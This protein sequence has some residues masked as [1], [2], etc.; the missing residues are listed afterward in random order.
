QMAFD[1][2]RNV[3]VL[4]GGYGAGGAVL[5][6]T[7]EWNGSS[8]TQRQ[9]NAPPARFNHGLAYDSARHVC[10]LVGGVNSGSNPVPFQDTWEWNG[11]AWTQRVV[12]GPTS[13]GAA[14]LAYDASRGATV[15]H[16]QLGASPGHDETWEW[17][18]T[19]WTER[20][21]GGNG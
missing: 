20:A 2:A 6:D 3:T 1:S 5:G 9:G 13:Y 12:A 16:G 14:W 8:W 4:F 11:S 10:V 17:N 18:G 15:A 7:W 21:N 19:L